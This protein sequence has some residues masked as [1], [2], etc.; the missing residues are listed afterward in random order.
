MENDLGRFRHHPN[1]AIDFCVEVEELTSIAT[2]R[3]LG[4]SNPDNGSLERRVQRAMEFRVGG[5]LNAIDAKGTLREI[6]TS[7]LPSK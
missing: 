4:V 3:R 6:E 2:D 7:L 1:P 5:D